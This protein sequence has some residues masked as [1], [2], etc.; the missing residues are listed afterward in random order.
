MMHSILARLL[1]HAS[2]APVRLPAFLVHS[3]I[4]LDP[5]IA[6]ERF[7]RVIARTGQKRR[8][9]NFGHGNME[10]FIVGATL[11]V[12]MR[13]SDDVL[14]SAERVCLSPKLWSTIP[15]SVQIALAGRPL[16]SLIGH[17]ATQGPILG[18]HTKDNRLAGLGETIALTQCWL[19]MKEAKAALR[20]AGIAADEGHRHTE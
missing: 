7:E 8:H 3:L 2:E 16:S 6:E 5:A 9:W 18:A 11:H 12:E 13:I 4:A 19:T 20:G 10:T 17:P 1:G 14:L 15:A